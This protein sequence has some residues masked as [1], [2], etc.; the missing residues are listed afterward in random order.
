VRVSR[1]GERFVSLETRVLMGGCFRGLKEGRP[2]ACELPSRA[3]LHQ[4]LDLSTAG[5]IAQ[6]GPA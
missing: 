2:V 4:I 1:F 5:S 3:D 6:T